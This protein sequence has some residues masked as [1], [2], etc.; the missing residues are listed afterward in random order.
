ME[1]KVITAAQHFG[2]V[3]VKIAKVIFV[4]EGP[5]GDRRARGLTMHE[6]EILLAHGRVDRS[7]GN[8]LI[9]T[10]WQ[11][12]YY[13]VEHIRHE[14]WCKIGS[15]WPNAVVR[16]P[17]LTPISHSPEFIRIEGSELPVAHASRLCL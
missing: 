6:F 11:V 2:G 13:T 14:N 16:F 15:S 17:S 1:M 3:S 5:R 7:E 8:V 9:F 12:P 10:H 4:F